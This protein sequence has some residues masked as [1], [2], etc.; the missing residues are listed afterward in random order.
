[1]KLR[2]GPRTREN[3]TLKVRAFNLSCAFLFF[4]RLAR[5]GAKI[6][7]TP[8]IGHVAVTTTNADLFLTHSPDATLNGAESAL[9]L[10]SASGRPRFAYRASMPLNAACGVCAVDGLNRERMPSSKPRLVPPSTS[11]DV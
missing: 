6:S 8:T 3:L 4:A 9:A 5:N 10:E 11:V 7:G 1:M 2:S